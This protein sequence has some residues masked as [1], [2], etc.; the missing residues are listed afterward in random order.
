MEDIKKA[1]EK[2]KKI[3]EDTQVEL[4]A[5]LDKLGVPENER[6]GAIERDKKAKALEQASINAQLLTAHLGKLLED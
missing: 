6:R 4:I 1:I 2:T 5:Y 3:A